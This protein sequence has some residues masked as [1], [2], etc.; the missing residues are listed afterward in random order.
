MVGRAHPAM[1]L[2]AE[3]LELPGDNVRRAVL[4]KAELRI[5]M[6]VAPLRTPNHRPY[7]TSHRPW[8]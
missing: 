7:Y 4:G 2:D 8:G 6:E 1:H 3:R 5:G